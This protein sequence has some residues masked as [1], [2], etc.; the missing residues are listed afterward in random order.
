MLTQRKVKSLFEYKNGCLYRLISVG[1][2]KKGDKAGSLS[3]DGYLHVMIEGYYYQIHRLIYL[4]HHGYIPEGI[5]H[6]NNDRSCNKI[7]NLRVATN[8]QNRWNSKKNKNN[9]SG[10]KG[11]SWASRDKK[12]VAQIKAS[13]KRVYYKEFKNLSEA[14]LNIEK[15]RVK[16]HLDF[17]NHG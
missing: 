11:V 5:D 3:S 1:S 7:D 15:E 6:K 8:T 16:L 9:K 13:G 17:T 2:T 10:V 14:T 12:W 4:Y